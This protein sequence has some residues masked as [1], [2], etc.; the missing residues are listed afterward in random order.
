MKAAFVLASCA[1]AQTV[2]VHVRESV[3]NVVGAQHQA[4][5]E[6][7]VQH[8]LNELMAQADKTGA[9]FLSQSPLDLPKELVMDV[10]KAPFPVINVLAEAP[11]YS[12]SVQAER[13]ANAI[14]ADELRTHAASFVQLSPGIPTGI[15]GYATGQQPIEFDLAPPEE[16]VRDI[17]ASIRDVAQAHA[18]KEAGEQRFMAQYLQM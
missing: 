13:N 15:S 17:A 4:L 10:N 6:R 18:V 1:A 5:A 14:L 16:D 3:A 7:V 11:S 12:A 9:S 2:T 8:R